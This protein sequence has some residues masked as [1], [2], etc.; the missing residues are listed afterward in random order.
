[1]QF[2][3]RGSKKKDFLRVLMYFTQII[4][5]TKHEK[6]YFTWEFIKT[7]CCVEIRGSLL[8]FLMQLLEKYNLRAP[9]GMSV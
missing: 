8:K 7:V 4:I 5:L 1:M 2:K 3:N 6:W 9:Q